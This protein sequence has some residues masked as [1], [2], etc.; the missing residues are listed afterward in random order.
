MDQN[1]FIFKESLGLITLPK[2]S[3]SKRIFPPSLCAALNDHV[4]RNKYLKL[5]IN[6]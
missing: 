5:D 2:L 1:F 6:L 4:T 3:S